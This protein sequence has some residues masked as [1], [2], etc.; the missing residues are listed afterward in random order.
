[1]IR[2]NKYSFTKISQLL[3]YSSIYSFSKSFKFYTGL[4]PTEYQKKHL[5][6]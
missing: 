6:G 2:E 3:N 4:T 5:K 1:L